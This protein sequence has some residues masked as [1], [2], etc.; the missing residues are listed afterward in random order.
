M[1]ATSFPMTA[2]LLFRL[3][4]AVSF[5]FMHAVEVLALEVVVWMWFVG[6]SDDAD[7]VHAL[8]LAF[9]HERKRVRKRIG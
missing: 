6:R 3:T 7:G 4:C 8:T 2:P 9:G 5:V 1:F